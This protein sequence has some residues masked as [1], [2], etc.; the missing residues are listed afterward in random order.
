MP[1]YILKKLGIIQS[2]MANK[3]KNEYGKVS[4]D[5]ASIFGEDNKSLSLSKMESLILKSNENDV[6]EWDRYEALHDDIT[7]QER[8]KPR[9]YEDN[10]EVVWEKGGS[11]LVYYTD[12]IIWKGLEGKFDF[13]EDTADDWDFDTEIYTLN[14]PDGKFSIFVI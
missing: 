10:M 8:T 1:S 9:L 12:D 5:Y 11:G 2:V 7:E 13:D 6:E 14:N 3:S 4:L